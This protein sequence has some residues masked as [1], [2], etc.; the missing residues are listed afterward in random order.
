MGLLNVAAAVKDAE[1]LPGTTSTPSGS[2]LV[3]PNQINE[4]T[5]A[6]IVRNH[7]ITVTNLSSSPE[8]VN[9]ST[10]TLDQE[11]SERSGTFRIHPRQRQTFIYWTGIPEIYT[12]KFFTVPAVPEGSVPR[13]EFSAAY[14]DSGQASPLHFLLLEPDGTYAAYSLPQGLGDYAEVEVANPPPGTW[15]AVFFTASPAVESE[16]K[17]PVQWSESTSVYGSAGAISPSTLDI[18]A[19]Q[20]AS[21]NLTLVSPTTPGDTSQSVVI[22]P[23]GGEATTIPVTVRTAIPMGPDGG[24][25]RGVLTGGNGRPG[26]DSQTNTYVFK[27]PGGLKDLDVSFAFKNDPVRRGPRLPGRRVGP[28][29]RVLDELHSH[30]GRQTLV[31]S[32]RAALPHEPERRAVEARPALRTIR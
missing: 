18:P 13:L 8:V 19:G 12:K 6:G 17:G 10:R 2:L 9:L 7:S 20:S 32:L 26:N 5:N 14:L 1:S 27:V 21:A 28:D 29:A 16:T 3:T 30:Q 24:S 22:A 4:V 15:T 31:Y 23:E 25:F 11:V